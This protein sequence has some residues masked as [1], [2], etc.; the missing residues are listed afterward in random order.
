LGSTPGNVSPPARDV[1]PDPVHLMARL[2]KEDALRK[3]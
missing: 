3:K 2:L 1:L